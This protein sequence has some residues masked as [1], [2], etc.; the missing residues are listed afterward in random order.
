MRNDEVGNSKKKYVD[1]II[2]SCITKT[3]SRN[4]LFPTDKS[5]KAEQVLPMAITIFFF[6]IS[7]H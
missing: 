6:T 4:G 7:L 1:S 3:H 5:A 2:V